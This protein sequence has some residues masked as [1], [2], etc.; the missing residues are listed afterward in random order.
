MRRTK[1]W[2]V[3]LAMTMMTAMAIP[4]TADAAKGLRE[5]AWGDR[6]LSTVTAR[7][8]SG[9]ERS[10]FSGWL[11]GVLSVLW[12]ATRGTIIPAVSG[13]GGSSGSEIELEPTG[14]GA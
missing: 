2:V 14:E 5:G 3:G 6:S 13:D 12:G 9:G 10:G 1:R 11:H 8:D 7:L 4:E